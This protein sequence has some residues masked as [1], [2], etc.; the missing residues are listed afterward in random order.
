MASRPTTPRVAPRDRSS[1]RSSFRSHS[2]SDDSGE[3]AC[4]MALGMMMMMMMMMIMCSTG[5]EPNLDAQTYHPPST[6][7]AAFPRKHY[8]CW[9]PPPPHA[10]RR[11]FL[12][13]FPR[14]QAPLF[15]RGPPEHR[16][17]SLQPP[18]PKTRPRN[19]RYPRGHPHLYALLGR[20]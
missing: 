16:R 2:P 6:G 9:P 20:P 15:L 5:Q 4:V 14:R 19:R 1:S 11:R 13:S 3:R 7:P 10:C 17:P 8:P 18:P 12:R